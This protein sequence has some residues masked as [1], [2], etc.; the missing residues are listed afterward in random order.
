MRVFDIEELYLEDFAAPLCMSRN[1]CLDENSFDLLSIG[2]FQGEDN[3]SHEVETV[4]NES[5]IRVSE[6]VCLKEIRDDFKPLA[7]TI[8][9]IYDRWAA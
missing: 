2:A 7:N 1:P 4:W 8:M 6:P 5:A 9:N 3:R